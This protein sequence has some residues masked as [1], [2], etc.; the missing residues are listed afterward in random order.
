MIFQNNLVSDVPHKRQYFHARA[1]GV[2]PLL[3]KPLDKWLEY[4]NNEPAPASSQVFF[5]LQEIHSRA[6]HCESLLSL[7]KLKAWHFANNYRERQLACGT[8]EQRSLFEFLSLFNVETR[9][10]PALIFAAIAIIENP[11]VRKKMSASYEAHLTTLSELFNRYDG[12]E[13]LQAALKNDRSTQLEID[14][15]QYLKQ[16]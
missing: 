3:D 1:I 16:M 10:Q 2:A 11:S 6:N 15:Y 14:W 12:A 9:R 5:A 7:E 13:R 8:A 4:L